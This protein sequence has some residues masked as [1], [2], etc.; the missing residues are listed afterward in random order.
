MPGRWIPAAELFECRTTQ[1]SNGSTYTTHAPACNCA[2]W[3][4]THS[5][6]H[7]N[8][9]RARRPGSQLPDMER[10]QEIN[11]AYARRWTKKERREHKKKNR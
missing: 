8:G 3:I 2:G 6:G 9:P 1:L 7:V 4:S 5:D 10:E 11:R